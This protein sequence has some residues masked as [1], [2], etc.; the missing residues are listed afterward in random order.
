SLEISDTNSTLTFRSVGFLQQEVPVSGK[1]EVSVVLLSQL[2]N[3]DE[4]V[5][6]GYGVQKKS[7]VTAAISSISADDIKNTSTVRIDNALKGM[8]SGVTVTQS[9]GQPG[10]GSK[11]RIRG[12]GTINNSD[13]LYIVDGMPIDGGIDYLNP[14]DISSIE[15]LKDAASG[16]VYGA[17]AANGVVLVTTKNGTLGKTRVDYSFSQGYQNRWQQ[18]DVLN[19]TEYAILMNEGLLNS[20]QNV[21]YPDPYSYGKGIDW[22][23]LVFNKNAPV[24]NHQLSISGASEKV[25]YFLSAGYYDQEG[26]VGGNWN[27]S[28][29][30]R[31]S[32]RSNMIFNLLDN[33]ER[34]FLHK[35]SLGVNASYSRTKSMGISTNSEYGSPLGS[36]IAF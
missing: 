26:I 32:L 36:A 11:V 28:N 6:V 15:V 25:N 20:G 17:R 3:L 2:S 31:M 9:S 1:T 13:P 29:Y 19:A 21:R 7:V 23:D 10:E 30:N 16:A 27:R 35:F 8:V 18:R 14:S 4:V 5:V 22:Q 24:S 33:Q 34:N 12:I